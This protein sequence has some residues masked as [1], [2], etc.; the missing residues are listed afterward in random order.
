MGKAGLVI[1]SS[2]S[3]EKTLQEIRYLIFTFKVCEKWMF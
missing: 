2:D 3:L 1:P